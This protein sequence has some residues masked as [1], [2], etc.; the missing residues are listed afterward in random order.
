L[1]VSFSSCAGSFT[2]RQRGSYQPTPNQ[3]TVCYSTG[4]KEKSYLFTQGLQLIQY[5]FSQNTPKQGVFVCENK[6]TAH[7]GVKY[8]YGN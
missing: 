5:Q 3:T 8:L 4:H 6:S 1:G 7:I 2:Q